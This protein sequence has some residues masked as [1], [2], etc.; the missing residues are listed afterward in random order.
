M[1]APQPPY[2]F[3]FGSDQTDIALLEFELDGTIN[4]CNRLLRKTAAYF[5]K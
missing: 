1:P 4:V 5:K 3:A 2:T